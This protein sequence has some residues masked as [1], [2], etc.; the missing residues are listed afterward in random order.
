VLS[1]MADLRHPVLRAGAGGV[2][3]D[4]GPDL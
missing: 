3:S 2:V 1:G 4:A